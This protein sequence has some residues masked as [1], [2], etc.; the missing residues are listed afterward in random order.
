MTNLTEEKPKQVKIRLW[1]WMVF[2]ALTGL[3]TF[4]Y[5]F[6]SNLCG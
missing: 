2:L 3:T 6:V 1:H 4:F 5:W